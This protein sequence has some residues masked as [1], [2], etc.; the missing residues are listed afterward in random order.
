LKY[1][2]NKVE[3]QDET[4]KGLVQVLKLGL[5]PYIARTPISRIL[6]LSYA[7]KVKPPE[8][9]DN[10]DFWVFSLSARGRLNGEKSWKSNSL[11]GNFSINRV[12]PQSRLRLGISGY[13]ERSEYDYDD[14]QAVSTSQSRSVDGMYV[15]SLGEHWSVGAILNVNHSTYGNIEFGLSLHPAI[16]YNIFPYSA[17]TRHE[18]R[19]LYRIGGNSY[20]YMEPTIYDKQKENTASHALSITFETREPWGSVEV[21]LEGSSLLRDFSF[22]RFKLQGNLNFRIFKGLALTADGRF[23]AIRDQLALRK[24]EVSV[25]ELLLRRA[26]LASGYSYQLSLGLSY[27]FGSVYSNI[28]NPRF[29][30]GFGGSG[31]DWGHY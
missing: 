18:L 26:E 13:N 8:V 29:G 7:G 21:S 27:S 22:N 19:I 2:S 30:G 28:V 5:T 23:S 20:R 16:E 3:T 12:T 24:S 14:Y 10:W 17:S 31:G 4:R 1:F 9:E 25:E 15:F 6:S 11:Y